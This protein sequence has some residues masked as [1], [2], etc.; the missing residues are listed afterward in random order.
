MLNPDYAEILSQ[1]QDHQVDFLLV[2]AYAMAIHGYPRATADIDIFV[3]ATPDNAARLI[4]ALMA[5]GAPLNGVTAAD[6]SHP[7]IVFQIGVAPRRIDILTQ[8][9]GLTF[10]E[11]EQ[12]KQEVRI[13][14]LTVPVISRQDLIRNKRASG[15]E[16]DLLDAK[17]LE[18]TN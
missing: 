6:F 14:D 2:G 11:A 7:G 1:L 15:R 3:H 4:T 16:K 18:I 10:E 13:G 9:D 12:H 5:F 8:I 17:Q